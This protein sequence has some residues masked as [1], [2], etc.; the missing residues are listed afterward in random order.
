MYVEVDFRVPQIRVLVLGEVKVL[1]WRLPC[2]TSIHSGWNSQW[3]TEA[4]GRSAE[5]K[6]YCIFRKSKCGHV[7]DQGAYTELMNTNH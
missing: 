2:F 4:V 6:N 7:T 1:V 3:G 5:Q